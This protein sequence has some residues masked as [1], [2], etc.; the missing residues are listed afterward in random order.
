MSDKTFDW[1]K[2]IHP[3]KNAGKNQACKEMF[4]P[5][6]TAIEPCRDVPTMMQFA[7]KTN[8][9]AAPLKLYMYRQ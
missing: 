2:N 4:T 9:P 3:I 7:G 1:R 8:G 5:I 6:V